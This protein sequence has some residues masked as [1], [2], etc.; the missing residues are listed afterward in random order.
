MRG[1]SC[2]NVYSTDATRPQLYNF[3][4][5]RTSTHI[6]R[7]SSC[8]NVESSRGGF[9]RI[10]EPIVGVLGEKLFWSVIV[11]E[12]EKRRSARFER[13]RRVAFER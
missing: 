4:G 13:N 9:V 7:G 8:R 10:V 6:V 5:R 12:I 1:P 3:E 2:Q 11:S